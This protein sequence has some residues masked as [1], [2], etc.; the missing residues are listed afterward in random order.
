VSAWSKSSHFP[1]EETLIKETECISHTF[2]KA[3][4][5]LKWKLKWIQYPQRH[6]EIYQNPFTLFSLPSGW[7]ITQYIFPSLPL[8][9][10]NECKKTFIK[11]SSILFSSGMFG[12]WTKAL[13]FVFDLLRYHPITGGQARR[14][15]DTCVLLQSDQIHL[16]I[17]TMTCGKSRVLLRNQSNLMV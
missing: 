9:P 14:L 13:S 2:T 11:T 5:R 17:T 3:L 15:A 12:F 1:R 7:E 4:T 10:E 6:Q 16:Y 8:P